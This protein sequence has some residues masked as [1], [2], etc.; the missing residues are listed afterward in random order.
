MPD[1]EEEAK[2][3]IE[4]QIQSPNAQIPNPNLTAGLM[5]QAVNG[6]SDLVVI[7]PAAGT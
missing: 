6:Q 7:Q 3:D 1:Y 2:S 4:V 5:I